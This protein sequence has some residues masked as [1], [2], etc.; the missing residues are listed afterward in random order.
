MA[1]MQQPGTSQSIPSP[2]T[3]LFGRQDDVSAVLELLR[4]DDVTVVTLLG[5]GG[6]GKTRLVIEAAHQIDV[7]PDGVVFITLAP[8][9][10]A[11]LVLS[12]IASAL[13]IQYKG[14]SSLL[15]HLASQLR[16]QRML[17]V[18]DNVEQVVEAAIT[19]S[20]LLERCPSLKLLATSRVALRIAGEYRYQVSPL[21]VPDLAR[22]PAFADLAST[23]AVALFVQRAQSE[24][25]SFALTEGNASTVAAICSRLNGL[26]LAIELAAARL[27]VLS[28][29]GI[30]ERLGESLKI[31]TGGARDQPTRLQTM[32]DAIAWSYDLLSLAEQTLFQQV[33]V[34]VGS[35]TLEAAAAIAGEQSSDIV[36]TFAGLVDQSLVRRLDQPDQAPRF[37]M[38]ETIREFGLEQLHVSDGE[39]EFRARHFTYYLALAEHT[40]KLPYTSARDDAHRLLEMELPNIRHALDWA[41]DEDDPEPLLRIVNALTWFWDY[42]SMLLEGGPWYERAIAKSARVQPE[43]RGQRALLLG[44]AAM[45]AVWRGEPAKAKQC[46]DEAL[47]LA[48]ETGEIPA[49]I[50]ALQASGQVSVDRGE[51][52]R[53]AS[54]YAEGLELSRKLGD[55]PRTLEM[56]YR[57]GYAYACRGDRET[58]ELFF[59]ECLELARAGGWRTPISYSLEALGTCARERGDRRRAAGL[60]AESLALIRDKKD[61]GTVGNCIRSIGAIAAAER[62]PEQ[63]ARLFGA[64]EKH[65]ERHGIGNVAVV[66]QEFRERDYALAREQM[67]AATFQALW[68]AG[69]ELPTEMAIAEA[70]SVAEA[71]AAGETPVAET[72]GGLTP[73][74]VQVLGLLVDG[75]SD[76]EIADRLFVSRHTA[77]NHVGSILSKLGVPSRAAAAAWAVRN[78]I[79]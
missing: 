75:L 5:P 68:S 19:L 77:A 36:G 21:A 38:L 33:S 25:S 64:A 16:D 63:A 43:L 69:R 48:R 52:E 54:E 10:D 42:R 22:L 78:G 39:A 44:N 24:D 12:A 11:D 60:Y 6:V 73:R 34:F 47:P 40:D 13:D 35:F 17:L 65:N 55:M 18:L 72:P 79:A 59:T 9:R 28:P 49:Q 51:L 31:L 2:R 29:A 57:V 3:P 56:T 1:T 30:L 71:I 61:P 26:P 62:Q 32:R 37:A 66:E 23:S 46:L 45:E 8:I 76:R 53:A 14:T 41:A 67:S 70:L 7:F 50:Q 15:E 27:T 74:E 20:N 58:A 4:R